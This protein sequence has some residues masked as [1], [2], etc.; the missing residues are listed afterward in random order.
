MADSKKP[1]DL[2]SSHALLGACEWIRKQSGALM[3]VAI[4]VEDSAIAADPSLAPK[5]IFPRL[6]QDTE[7]LARQV[8]QVRVKRKVAEDAHH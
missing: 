7:E 1:W 6:L 5:D 4:R 3:V 2:T 8:E